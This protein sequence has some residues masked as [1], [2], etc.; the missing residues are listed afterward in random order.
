MRLVTVA[1]ERLRAAGAPRVGAIVGIEE[2]GAVGL[3]RAAGYEH[4]T[5]LGRFVRNL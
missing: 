5:R 1:H 4:D 3:W 2:D